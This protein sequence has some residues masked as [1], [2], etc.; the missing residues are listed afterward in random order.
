MAHRHFLMV[1]DHLRELSELHGRDLRY[2]SIPGVNNLW[3]LGVS[4]RHCIAE[5]LAVIPLSQEARYVSLR[6]VTN[7]TL[8]T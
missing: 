5:R 7:T 4:T 6:I 2:G 3:H 8:Y 1:D